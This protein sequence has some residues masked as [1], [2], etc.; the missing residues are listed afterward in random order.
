MRGQQTI[1]AV[2]RRRRSI[3]PPIVQT[4]NND[5]PQRRRPFAS[6]LGRGLFPE[7]GYFRP[8]TK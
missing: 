1:I 6:L 3:H 7:E 2:G 8:R 4:I 5:D